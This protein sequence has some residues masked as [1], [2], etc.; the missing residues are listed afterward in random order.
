MS[1]GTNMNNDNDCRYRYLSIM[2]SLFPIDTTTLLHIVFNDLEF[3]KKR[4][5]SLKN[6]CKREVVS[7]RRGLR[8][9]ERYL[10]L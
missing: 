7:T 10:H 3:T 2:H 8:I 6:Q 9:I 5:E 4:F 1:E